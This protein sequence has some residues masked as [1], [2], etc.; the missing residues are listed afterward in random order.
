MNSEPRPIGRR[1][2]LAG[3]AGLTVAAGLPYGTAVAAP[4]SGYD[5]PPAFAQAQQ[6]YLA[7][8]FEH[9]EAGGYAW[10]ESY[11][12]LGLLRMYQAY[13]DP[14]YLDTFVDRAEHLA[15]TTDRARGVTDYR[16]RSGPVWRTSNAYTAAHGVIT[17]GTGAA[18]IQV[19][20]AGARAAESTAEISEVAAD[21]FTLTLRN[22]ASA[23]VI[24]R[25]GVSLD[26]ASP[27]YAVTVIN[28]GY[29]PG[30]RWTA[31]DLR[32][33]P[34]VAP[35]PAAGTITFTSQFYVYAVHTGMVAY[36]LALFA[37]IVAETPKLRHR[38]GG[39]AKR[40]GAAAAAAIAFHDEE[41]RIVD[42]VGD[43]VWPKG[44]PIPFD[45]LI[46]PYNQSHGPGQAMAELYRLT[47]AKSYRQK[48]T[49]MLEGFA[50][51]V[52]STADG[53][54]VWNYWPPHSELYNG[55]AAADQLSTY[56]PFYSAVRSIED[57]SHAAIT[58]EFLAAAHA[59]GIRHDDLDLP[60]VAKTF[61]D[62]VIRSETEVWFRIDGSADAVPGNAVQAAR[63]MLYARYDTEIY[64]QCLR[65][66]DAAALVPSQGSHALG[67]GYL[68]W[69]RKEAWRRA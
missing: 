42:G 50:R 1:A 11:F 51:G 63:W 9:N 43:Y 48:I 30:L 37:R 56:T 67:I 53:A 3:A 27:N 44:A 29:G 15:A 60:A 55:Y 35:A 16:G 24:T 19:R 17:D 12:L 45:G 33:Q 41:F 4:E 69:A 40:A 20:W 57:I 28:A 52:T 10:G 22:P 54:Y 23:T 6:A 36:P 39:A 2:V 46:Q 25:T 14:A 61:V 13:G 38:Y 65:V 66:Y 62:N 5:Q 34:A 7:I 32:D 58:I 64:A 59:A 49:A 8:G 47:R 26:P 68:N 18:A 21:T 31:I